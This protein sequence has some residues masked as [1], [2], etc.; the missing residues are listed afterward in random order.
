ML[1]EFFFYKKIT[2]QK[3]GSLKNADTRPCG[4]KSS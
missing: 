1:K 2:T 4:E 3:E